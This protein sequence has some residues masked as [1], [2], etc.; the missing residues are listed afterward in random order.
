MAL[1]A[2]S[3]QVLC[4]TLGEAAEEAPISLFSVH[5]ISPE[6]DGADASTPIPLA[7]DE[8]GPR[9]RLIAPRGGAIYPCQ[10]AAVFSRASG[11]TSVVEGG[12]FSQ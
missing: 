1:T 5:R 2:S 7:I 9:L 8:D 6:G 12:F 4:K 11:A 3:L 10:L